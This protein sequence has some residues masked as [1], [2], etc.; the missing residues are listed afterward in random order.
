[1]I[2]PMQQTDLEPVLNLAA[3][4]PEAP[5]WQHSSYA[6]Y[7]APLTNS[8]LLRTGLVVI[9]PENQLAEIQA[10]AAA[11]LLL[12]GEQNLCQLDS[13]AVHPEARRRGIATVLLRAL[14]AWAAQNRAHHFSLEVRAGNA[15]ALAL[16]QHL[17]FRPEGRRSRYYTHPE[18]D[19]LILGTS[20]TPESCSAG[21]PR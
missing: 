15:P 2:R 4:C 10:F 16:Y 6:A 13:I 20:V 1:M 14:L 17:G 9:D 3:A 11:T 21:F 7:L 19:A 18:E 12:D 8:H 5:Q